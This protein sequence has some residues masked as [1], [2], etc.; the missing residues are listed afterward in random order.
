[1]NVCTC[2]S[3]KTIIKNASLIYLEIAL[4]QLFC[5]S[6]YFLMRKIGKVEEKQKNNLKENE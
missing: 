6:R 1:M 4:M 5:L 2:T 3:I